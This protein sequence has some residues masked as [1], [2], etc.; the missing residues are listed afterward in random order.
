MDYADYLMLLSP[1]ENVKHEVARY[2][3][4]SAKRI[5][6]FESMDAPAHISI[7]SA[8]R[9]KSFIVEPAL[10]RMEDRLRTM[11]PVALHITG[12]NYFKHGDKAMTIYAEIK[13]SD[14]IKNW[15]KLLIANM[16]IKAYALN[17]HITVARNILPGSFDT[18][19]PHFEQAKCQELFW[20][21]EL[22]ILK[23]ETFGHERNWKKHR[24]IGFKNQLRGD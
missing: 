16:N 15:F 2:K 7:Y 12:F 21:K 19:W 24:L 14:A 3:K 5:G 20:I 23:R 13:Q 22:T 6:V 18:L 8:E 9:Q 11:P 4:A 1:P 17:P 10:Q